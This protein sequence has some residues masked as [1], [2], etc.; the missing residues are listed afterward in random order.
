M[1]T[2][3]L[4]QLHVYLVQEGEVVPCPDLDAYRITPP[5]RVLSGIVGEPD[6]LFI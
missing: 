2:H 4:N 6:D 5:L 1:G 3:D